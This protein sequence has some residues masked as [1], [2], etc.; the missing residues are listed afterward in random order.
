MMVSG[1][2]APGERIIELQFSARLG[3]SRTPLRLALSELEKEGLLE[4]LPSRGFRV[5]AFSVDDI[6]DAVDVRGVLE[7]MAARMVAQRGASPLWL[8]EMRAVVEEGRKLVEG[9]EANPRSTVDAVAWSQI[10]R[11]FH[12]LLIGEARNRAL[13]SALEHNNKTPLTGPAALPLPSTP[14]FLETPF[15]LRAQADH[16]DLLQAIERREA[17]RA[18]NIMREH[19]YHS[20]E[21]KRKLIEQMRR[22][23][24]GRPEDETSPALIG[25]GPDPHIP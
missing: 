1:E 22:A 20:R 4:R 9:A 8:E 13:S 5:R 12:D 23:R 24:P 3:V 18:E 21:N 15:V 10:N 11:R 17:T 25:P 16:E 14:S 6:A 2:L 7:G 19:A